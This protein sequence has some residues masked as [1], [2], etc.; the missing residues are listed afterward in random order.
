MER[1]LGMLF[2][3]F[4]FLHILSMFAAVAATVL[5][6]VVLHLVANTR[7]ARAIRTFGLITQRIGKV[8]PVLFISGVAFG[9]LAAWSGSLDFFKPWLIGAYVLFV[10]ATAIGI[11]YTDPWT[12]RVTALAGSN[13]TES[14]S[15]DLEAAIA[16]GR[17]KLWSAILMVILVTM[18]F[19]MVFK[20]GN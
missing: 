9:L 19:L 15:P 17:A 10:A 5:P 12:A 11:A 8:T 1:S 2:T 3:L 16:D 4:K 6:E 20:P 18:I 14:A 13:D 7:D